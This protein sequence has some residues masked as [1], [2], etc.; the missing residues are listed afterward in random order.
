MIFETNISDYYKIVQSSDECCYQYILGKLKDSEE[1]YA[2]AFNNTKRNDELIELLKQCKGKVS[3]IS[4]IDT[5]YT[6]KQEELLNGINGKFNFDESSKIIMTEKAAFI[7][8]EREGFSS[9]FLTIDID[10]VEEIKANLFKKNTNSNKEYEGYEFTRLEIIFMNYYSKVNRILEEI[11]RDAFKEDSKGNGFYRNDAKINIDDLN[12]LSNTIDD[13]NNTIENIKEK[14]LKDALIETFD[15]DN[16][17]EL[18][19]IVSNKGNIHNLALLEDENNRADLAAKAE[20]EVINLYEKINLFQEE[21][22]GIVE[23]MIDIKSN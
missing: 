5:E 12:W 16:L 23:Q 15:K 7:G 17:L 10:V 11:I 19:K 3:L 4:D 21:L 9:G 18:K 1:V 6:I 2:F 14:E 8:T 20:K 13:F 22:Y